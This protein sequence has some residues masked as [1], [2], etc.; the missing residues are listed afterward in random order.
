MNVRISDDAE[1]DLADGI[2]FYSHH[3]DLQNKRQGGTGDRGHW[4]CHVWH[5]ATG[6]GIAR[7]GVAS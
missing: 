1:R 5:P 2:A 4:E 3:S 6:A 7:P